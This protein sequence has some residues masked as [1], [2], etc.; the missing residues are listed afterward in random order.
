[1]GPAPRAD[2][3]A[4]PHAP[5]REDIHQLGD[6]LGGVLRAQDG[7]ALLQ[8]VEQVRTLAKAARQGNP[9]ARDRLDAV[10]AA[11]SPADALAVARAFAQFLSLSNLAEQ[12]H[13]VR[14]RRAWR[15]DPNT[16]P[17]RG[18]VEDALIR[19]QAAG[20]PARSL[21]AALA[22]QRVELVLTAHPTEVQRR[23][24]LQKHA[25][26]ATLLET[27]ERVALLPEERA[28]LDTAL[29][30]E[31]TALWETDELRPTRPTPE[32]EVKGGLYTFE[33]PLW[34]AV[35]AF[36]RTLDTAM[37]RHLGEALPVGVSP[38][39]FGSWIGGDRDGNPNITA[40]VT[41]RACLLG[42]WMGADLYAREVDRLRAELSMNRCDPELRARV[43]NAWEPYRALLRDVR[44]RLRATRAWTE[45]RLAGLPAG[46]PLTTPPGA[47]LAAPAG[48]P[49]TAPPGAPTSRP[50]DGPM[51]GPSQPGASQPGPSRAGPSQAGPSQAGRFRAGR[52]LLDPAE[53]RD[54]LAL[55]DRSLRACGDGVLADGRLADLL[56][57]VDAFGLTLA[58][59]DAR[60]EASRHTAALDTITRH[61]GLGA[62]ADWDEPRR[63]AWLVAELSGRRPLVP[64]DLAASPDVA[65]VLATFAA[66]A[67]EPPGTLGAYVI[68]MASS[69]SD[70]LAVEL[71]QRDARMWAHRLPDAGAAGNRTPPVP[72]GPPMRVVPLFET[73]ADLEHA[74]DTVRALLGIPWY[75]AHL[76]EVHGGRQEV[77]IGYSDSAKD[78]GRLASAWALYR[79]QEAVVAA[80]RDAG[81]I[82][83]LFHGRG[84]TVGRGGAPTHLAILAQPPGSVE[85]GLRVTE[86]GE[87]IQAK[88]GLPGIAIRNLELYTSAVLE[89]RFTPPAAPPPE[90][91][92]VMDR[93]AERSCA[94]WRRVVKADPRFVP[95]FRAITPVD[96]LGRLNIG[97]RPPRRGTAGGLETLRAI[98]WN[99]AWTQVRWMVPAWLGVADA[100]EAE[101][102]SVIRAMAAGWPFFRTTLEM[103]E[104]I[105]AKAL[106]DVAAHYEALLVPPELRSIGAELAA[107]FAATEAAVLAALGRRS[108][109]EDSPVLARSIAVRNPYVDPLNLLQAALLRRLRNG[110]TDPLLAR[111][112]LVTVNGI[113]A[114]MRNTG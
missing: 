7:P 112:F 50:S 59:L 38:I 88:F 13:R 28:E 4:D 6:L 41:R 16:P 35:P 55:C 25:T 104:M 60:Q 53:L 67:E 95:Y 44:D 30:R 105:F 3:Q 58:R 66:L 92:V 64:P 79:A 110:G 12:V 85:G 19:L 5:L 108:L 20:I 109:L 34:D 97:S 46:A 106:P 22:E 48:A 43:G 57:R 102:P 72:V 114:G 111:A 33:Q 113:A 100:L 23:T 86:Q 94:A 70:V 61:L 1:M 101:D 62:Y 68:S 81:V 107:R 103:V 75:R 99:F 26:I 96:E 74:G 76:G 84:G 77:M 51:A 89:A 11:L 82:P 9:A 42:R 47:P 14:R 8:R 73:L 91:R 52:L 65:E 29:V 98:P 24:V 63:Q 17:Q 71:L 90:W 83:T 80:C 31:V 39:R 37:R 15:S 27:R 49:L 87:V 18:S 40:D 69:P 56:R 10:L 93:L 45:A 32:D 21:A 2:S 78:A 54:A 36:L